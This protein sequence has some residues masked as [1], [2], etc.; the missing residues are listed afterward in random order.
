MNY[1]NA[2]DVLPAE[3]LKEIQKYAGG[4][5]LYVPKEEAEAKTWG[6]VSGQKKYFKRR[7]RMLINKFKYGITVQQLAKEYCLSADTV[8][9]IVYSRKDSSELVFCPD[10]NSA[11]E[12]NDNQL[13]EEWIHTYLLFE[14]KNKVF[15][16]G[17]YKETRYYAGPL[18][19]PLSLLVRNSGPEEDMKWQVNGEVFECR[20]ESW[21]EKIRN[22]TILPPIIVGYTDGEFEINCNSPLFEA[23]LRENVTYFPVIMWCTSEHDYTDFM[24]KYSPYTEFVLK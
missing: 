5:L 24:N 14:R 11:K 16:D 17:L 10:I 6:E 1:L 3:L 20:V 23:L 7:N 22:N 9:K 4:T 2:L 13:L 21:R 18:A 12:Y 8:K 19:M 15:S